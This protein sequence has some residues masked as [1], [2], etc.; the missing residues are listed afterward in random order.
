MK[1]ILNVENKE[2]GLKLY[3]MLHTALCRCDNRLQEN[4]WIIDDIKSGKKRLWE[5][6][7]AEYLKQK[8]KE[9]E[10]YELDRKLCVNF[11]NQ[12]DKQVHAHKLIVERVGKWN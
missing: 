7:T 1:I 3:Y 9:K 8:L 6:D 2:E 5:I 4:K 11:I 12:V 10:R